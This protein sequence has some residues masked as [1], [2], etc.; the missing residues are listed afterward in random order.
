MMS[1]STHQHGF[2]AE[3]PDRN[4]DLGVLNAINV[5][6]RETIDLPT[7]LAIL[8]G[9]RPIGQWQ[10]HIRFFFEVLPFSMAMPFVYRHRLPAQ[11]VLACYETLKAQGGGSP[12]WET[13]RNEQLGIFV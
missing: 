3:S 9:D 4:A 6:W 12:Q 1:R 2:A 5:C 7:L 11:G 13:W 10:E 8:R